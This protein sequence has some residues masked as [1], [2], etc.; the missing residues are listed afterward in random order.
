MKYRL[1]VLMLILAARVNAQVTI[2]P[3]MGE[4]GKKCNGMFMLRNDSV[5]PVVF[6]V[7]AYSVTFSQEKQG[8]VQK[9]LNDVTLKLSQSSGRLSPKESRQIEFKFQCAELPCQVMFMSAMTLTK[10]ING[11]TVRFMLPFTAYSDTSA[12]GA[13]LRCLRAAGVTPPE[14]RNKPAEEHK[15]N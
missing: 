12:K 1:L 13:R 14:E 5:S 4:C 8:P 15:G 9:P 10:P 6:T 7:D 2:A 11:M 3:F